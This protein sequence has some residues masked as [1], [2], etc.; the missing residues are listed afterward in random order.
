MWPRLRGQAGP[1][2]DAGDDAP[3]P[4]FDTHLELISVPGA[5]GNVKHSLFSLTKL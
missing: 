3:E 5:D 4:E 1:A 2:P